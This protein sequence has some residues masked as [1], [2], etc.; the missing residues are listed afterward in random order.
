MKGYDKIVQAI[1]SDIVFL[2]RSIMENDSVS[3]NQK[4]KKG[5]KNTL[6][7][8][9]LKDDIGSAIAISNDVV[10]QTLFRHYIS[11]IEWDRPKEY[12]KRPPLDSLRDWALSKG[13]PTD[14]STL[15]AISNAI[16]R[17]GHKGR[18]ILATL[19]KDVIEGFEKEWYNQ[20]F[21]SLIDELTKYF[22]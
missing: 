13:I 11:Y 1:A 2:A 18:P 9:S 19:E 3:S 14:N 5:E 12:G 22:N 7:N 20:I 16:W 8:S 4:V 6:K 17:D 15:W 10:I 21:E